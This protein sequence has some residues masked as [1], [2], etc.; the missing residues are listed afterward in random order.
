MNLRNKFR[1]STISV[2]LVYALLTLAIA[3]ALLSQSPPPDRRTAVNRGAWSGETTSLFN[4]W[5]GLDYNPGRRLSLHSPDDKKIIEVK[6]ET[7]I[8]WIDGR[9]YPTKL[10]EKTN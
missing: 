6:D 9:H 10:G 2:P 4:T 3:P 1:R 8:L 7:V 5:G